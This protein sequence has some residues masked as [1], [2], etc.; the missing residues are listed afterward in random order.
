[1][2]MFL[3]KPRLAWEVHQRVWEMLSAGERTREIS[4][5]TGVSISAINL[6][7]SEA[8]GVFE[9][10]KTYSGR[11]L[12]ILDRWEIARLL[13][14]GNGVNQIARLMGRAPSTISREL[15]RNHDPHTGRY[16]PGSAQMK[17]QQR[18]RRPKQRI[19]VANP[20]LCREVQ[21]MLDKHWSPEQ[22]SGRIRADFSDDTSMR[23]SPE[24]I[25]QC[26]YV[27]PVGELERLLK[28]DLRSRHVIRRRQG[29]QK[30]DLNIPDPVSIH[31]RPAEVESREVPGHHEGDLILGTVAS[32][33]AIGTIVERT[34][35]YLTL[36]HLPDGKR[37]QHVIDQITTVMSQYPP[38]LAK[39]LTW[40]RG[41][42][43]SRH[44]QLTAST[45]I[46]VYFADPHSPWQR[47][48]NENIN[49]LLRQY[50]PKSTDLSVHDAAALQFVQ[51]ELNDRPRKRFGFR[52]PREELTRLMSQEG[53]ATT[54]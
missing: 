10:V 34:T 44:R 6:Y 45:G 25:Y 20:R 38:T 32:K 4:R 17:A 52:T 2:R 47:G 51:D 27:K 43:M 12:S 42:E 46:Q 18:Q 37:P 7:K 31:D 5:E 36:V 8:G 9:P 22:V 21:A 39:S 50:F 16:I 54:P 23:I 1:M 15:A 35:G 3:R 14:A 49:G 40:D 19:L 26:I 53:V 30:R 24:T 28:A 33:S 48:S 11:Y 13:D 29:R 41:R